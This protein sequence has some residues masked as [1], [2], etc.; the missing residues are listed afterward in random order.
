[1]LPK[2]TTVKQIVISK[3]E[4]GQRIDNF[5]HRYFGNL[6]KS[7][8]YQMLRKGEVRVNKGRIKQTYKLIAGDEIRIPPVY[9]Q[10]Q[11]N[12]EKPTAAFIERISNSIIYEDDDLSVINKP[13]GIAVHGGTGQ[14]HGVIDVLRCISPEY[15]LVH[16]LDKETSGCLLLA[17]NRQVL[18]KLNEAIKTTDV[19]KYYRAL[20]AGQI[21]RKNFIVNQ[22]LKK[23]RIQGGERLV[24]IDGDGKKSLTKFTC[25]SK[26]GK[27]TL[28]DVELGTGRTHQIRVHSAEIGHPVIGDDKYGDKIINKTFRRLGLKRMFLHA[29]RIS[30]EHPISGANLNIEAPLDL[31]LTEFLKTL[32]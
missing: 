22:S 6:P 20:L 3:D 13:S 28:V 23:S 15:E 8:V 19:K 32:Q 17:K 25:V 24:Q 1:M 7:R 31:K 21:S 2:K 10:E 26:F 16:R 14:K 9:L 12:V 29:S 4:S 5:L 18:R 11:N 27:A 30:L